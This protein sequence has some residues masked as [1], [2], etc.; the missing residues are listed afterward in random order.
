LISK[1][2]FNHILHIVIGNDPFGRQPWAGEI[3]GLAIYDI[4]LSKEQ[5]FENYNKWQ[6]DSNFFVTIKSDILALYPIDEQHG[7]SIHNVVKSQ[8]NLIIPD[9]FKILKKSYLGF[10][11]KTLKLA[12]TNLL[13]LF[14]NI[15]GFIPLGV[16][17]FGTIDLYSKSLKPSSWILIIL[18]IIGGIA[19]SLIVE[20]LQAYLPT[21]NSSLTDIIFNSF[22]TGVG[23]FFAL[24]LKN[25]APRGK[26]RGIK[27]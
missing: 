14:V 16:F 3:H 8:N 9:R 13:D 21:R 2:W 22:G 17:F 26:L 6:H 27:P 11:E 24:I 7:K 23:V 5:V 20:I 19:I 1:K 4:A 15:V 10:S 12:G 18:A 25:E